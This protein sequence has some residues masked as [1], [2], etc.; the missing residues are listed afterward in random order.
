MLQ[1]L[2]STKFLVK[3]RKF[4][5]NLLT[6]VFVFS[7]LYFCDSIFTINKINLNLNNSSKILNISGLEELKQKNILLINL[8]EVEKALVARNPQ[9]KKIAIKKKYPSQI[10]IDILVYEAYAQIEVSNGF[11]ILSEDGRILEKV[12]QMVKRL[13]K[14]NYYQKLNYFTF[15]P[16]DFI[17]YE[18][19]KSG[20]FFLR[21]L[22]GSSFQVND[23]DIAD[24]DM[25]LFNV[26][27]KK[28]IF[29]TSKNK[30]KQIIEAKSILHQFKIEGKYWQSIDLRFDKPIIKF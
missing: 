28:I 22:N 20:L 10:E 12:K 9:V 16:G 14:I 21:F 27:D 7:I 5:L 23:L 6:F 29:T 2:W 19:I 25:L 1:K 13:P 3:I 8:K 4:F 30:E 18:D 11:F 17:K 15:L 24:F 26:G